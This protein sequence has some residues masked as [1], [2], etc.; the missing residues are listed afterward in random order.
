M[1]NRKKTVK[2]REKTN[3]KE[4]I[5]KEFKNS[6]K[7]E[8]GEVKK[9]T[10]NISKLFGDAWLS[11]AEYFGISEDSVKKFISNLQKKGILSPQESKIKEII[12]KARKNRK[13]MEEKIERA[14]RTTF[15]NIKLPNV[16]EIKTEIKTIN[17]KVENAL[18]KIKGV[19]KSKSK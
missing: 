10:L 6:V 2:K 9:N 5:G 16:E 8:E 3:E 17:T 1:A 15:E 19:I 18:K 13:D 11:I 12:E 14:I 4:M 7:K